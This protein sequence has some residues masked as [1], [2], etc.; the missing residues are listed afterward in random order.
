MYNN[1]G[2][3]MGMGMND[4]SAMNMMNY[5]G[6]YGNGWNGMGGGYGNF[7]GFNQMGGYN[8]SGAYPEMMNQFPKNNFQNQNQNRI[9]ASQG[10]AHPQ[11]NNR[12][13]SQ[14]GSISW[15]GGQS[16]NSR[17]GSRS[18]PA[19]NVRRSHK[20]LPRRSSL[21]LY[22][23]KPATDD[24]SVQQRAGES[25]DA[26]SGAAASSKPEDEQDPGVKPIE[27]GNEHDG[28]AEGAALAAGSATA[29]VEDANNSAASGEQ[30]DASVQSNGLN[31]IQTVETEDG[32]MQGYNQPMMGNGMGFHNGMMNQF[33]NQM[34]MNAPFDPTMNMGFHQT[35]NFGPRAGFNAAYGAATVLTGEPQ[36]RG[37]AGAP[38][39]PRAMREG[40]PNTGFSSRMNNARYQPPPKSVAST[41]SAGARSPQRTARS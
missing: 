21:V 9:P 23:L 29:D 22:R 25:P 16:V 39:G 26:S 15:P 20:H 28:S 32:D 19:Q 35:N 18:G 5:G 2:G 36:G 24:I 10:G 40:R 6:G 3:N 14:A 31:Q 17:P 30:N 13:G 1:F 8:Q 38:T 4:M 12:A 7:N 27:E 41:Q 37:V 33:P 34:Q 11:T